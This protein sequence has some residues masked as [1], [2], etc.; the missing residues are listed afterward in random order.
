MSNAAQT[1]SGS[2]KPVEPERA[3]AGRPVLGVAR[4]HR[5]AR[6][7]DADD[8]PLVEVQEVAV[9]RRRARRAELAA[10]RCSPRPAA[11]STLT[12]DAAA[13]AQ[14]RHGRRAASSPASRCAAGAR[15]VVGAPA[16]R[17]GQ[18]ARRAARRR[19]AGAAAGARVAV[20][21]Q[22][23]GDVGDQQAAATRGQLRRAGSRRALQR[24]PSSAR[25]RPPSSAGVALGGH[26]LDRRCPSRSGARL[27]QRLLDRA[28]PA[29]RPTRAQPSQLP[30][31]PQ[32]RHAVLDAEQLDVAARATR[33][34]GAPRRAPR[35]RASPAATG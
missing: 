16:G 12:R 32:V 2:S 34:R 23:A 5:P 29:S 14:Q 22:R 20:G 11:V 19:A 13:A 26:A 17:A 24:A 7:A 30:M 9:V 25:G 4:A 15:Q 10:R 8:A 31:Q 18:R 33:G 6:L 21:E 1:S 35:A 28:A 3:A 27:V